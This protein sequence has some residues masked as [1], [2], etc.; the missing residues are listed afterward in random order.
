MALLMVMEIALLIYTLAERNLRQ[1]LKIMNTT[2]P[3][4]KRKPTQRLTIRWIYQFNQ[5]LDILL[6]TQDGRVIF[7]ELL[8]LCPTQEQAITLLS[9]SV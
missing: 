9:L 5:G 1:A 4:Q 2:V 6:V 8:N 7:R 3:D